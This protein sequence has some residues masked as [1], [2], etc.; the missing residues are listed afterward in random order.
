MRG[1]LARIVCGQRREIDLTELR[2]SEILGNY[3][4]ARLLS[5]QIDGEWRFVLRRRSG[6]TISKRP[7]AFA[8]QEAEPHEVQSYAE[9]R[10]EGFYLVKFRRFQVNSIAG[11]RAPLTTPG[12]FG[13]MRGSRPC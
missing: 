9:T 10:R 4:G 12:M 6:G 2:K 11:R 13:N 8:V 5:L 3:R 7:D 1:G